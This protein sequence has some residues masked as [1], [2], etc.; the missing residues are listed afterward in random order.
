MVY[1][2]AISFDRTSNR[3]A[4][5]TVR[6]TDGGKT[7]T[8]L[9]ILVDFETN[10]G[11][12]STDKNSVMYCVWGIYLSPNGNSTGV[13]TVNNNYV[14]GNAMGCA[15]MAGRRPRGDRRQRGGGGGAGVEEPGEAV[16]GELAERSGLSDQRQGVQRELV[17]RGVDEHDDAELADGPA[18]PVRRG[19]EMG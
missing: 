5:A 13:F 7:W 2:N 12:F 17:L 1:A 18:G 4:V 11:Q 16:L 3:N 19:H 10:G 8:N 15:R 14:V 9:V 6:S